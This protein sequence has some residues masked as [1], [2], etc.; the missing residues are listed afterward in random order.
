MDS[1]KIYLLPGNASRKLATQ[2][3]QYWHRRIDG[4]TLPSDGSEAELEE[5][6]RMLSSRVQ[7]DVVMV[8][9]DIGKFRDSEVSVVVN[10]NIRGQ[11]VFIVQSFY[12]GYCEVNKEDG[13]TVYEPGESVNDY[14]M[15]L[16]L[17]VDA[18]KRASAGS[19]TAVIPY[20][21][22]ARQ[23]RKIQRAPISAKLVA[24][25]LTVAGVS[26]VV[27]MDLHAAQVQGFFNVPVDNLYGAVV[28]AKHLANVIAAR[29]RT[30]E[31]RKSLVIV[32]PDVGGAQRA[33]KFRE[34][35]VKTLQEEYP[36]VGLDKK[37]D[38]TKSTDEEKA[39]NAK[40]DVDLAIID[41]VRKVANEAEV[42]DVIGRVKGKTAIIVDDLIDTAGT[43]CKGAQALHD[44]GAKEILAFCTHPVMSDKYDAKSGLTTVVEK[45]NQSHIDKLY[46][47][48]TIPLRPDQEAC[49]KIEVLSQ[50]YMFAS[51]MDGIFNRKSVSQVFNEARSS[52]LIPN[53]Q[54]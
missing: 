40:W 52:T 34:R 39:Q 13:S 35:L 9:V 19:I 36:S 46:V 7:N 51:A 25:M 27:T 24:D 31:E 42:M 6:E 17:T 38:G 54:Q 32:S 26:R 3:S 49:E 5:W 4:A 22:Y 44:K 28:A 48:D 50:D 2:I 18:C 29:V 14:L 16:L 21:G 47:S 41:K 23:D 45:L 37:A 43:L 33:R 20:F 15:A 11:D 8:K 1:N 10:E 53:Y 12:T 30:I